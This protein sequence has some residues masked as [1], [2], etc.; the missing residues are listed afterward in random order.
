M[1]LCYGTFLG[2][3][4]EKVIPD[5]SDKVQCLVRADL[6]KSKEK[7]EEAVTKVKKTDIDEKVEYLAP[8]EFYYDHQN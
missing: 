8:G 5:F 4:V 6:R 1:V 2:L 3:T 7:K